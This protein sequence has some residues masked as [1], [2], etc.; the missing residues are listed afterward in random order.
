MCDLFLVLLA[1]HVVGL[2][3][4]VMELISNWGGPAN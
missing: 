2:M 1:V 4:S 3:L